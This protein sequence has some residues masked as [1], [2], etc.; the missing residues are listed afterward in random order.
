MIA[1]SVRT[2]PVCAFVLVVIGHYVYCT[3]FSYTLS[4]FNFT[5]LR[6]LCRVVDV[7]HLIHHP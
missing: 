1:Q 4:D 2:S 7:K 6:L 5:L 3:R